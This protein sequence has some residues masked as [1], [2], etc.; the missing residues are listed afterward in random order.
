MELDAS[1]ESISEFLGQPVLTVILASRDAS[2]AELADWRARTPGEISASSA[3]G[4]ANRIHDR[5]VYHM[6]TGLDDMSDVVYNENGPTR[7]F[8][9]KD[10]IVL[11]CKRHDKQ[12][13]IK[14]YPTRAAMNH[15][16]GAA[17]LEGLSMLNLAAGYRWDKDLREMGAAVLS[18]RRGLDEQ[19]LW[20]VE[21]GRAGGQSMPVRILPPVVPGLPSIDLFGLGA[22]R[23]ED[24]GQ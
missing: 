3:R 4:L 5:F 6:L 13:K 23:Q 20:I 11:R 7:Q 9:V 10:R 14:A 17:T 24:E 19:P 21:L 22:E 15:W 16:G 18:F 12:N 8:V 2:A 1:A